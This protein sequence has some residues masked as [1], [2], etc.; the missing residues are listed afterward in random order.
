MRYF[1]IV[2][3]IACVSFSAQAQTDTLNLYSITESGQTLLIGGFVQTE[4]NKEGHTRSFS[5]GL[6]DATFARDEQFSMTGQLVITMGSDT[7]MTFDVVEVV[8]WKCPC[9]PRVA[10]ASE[11][12][13]FVWDTK[14]PSR[15]L[16]FED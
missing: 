6:M 10:M 2:I 8:D 14:K 9:P 3:A 13:K 4:F 11:E 1:L 5:N 15:F 16:Y 7:L 12:S